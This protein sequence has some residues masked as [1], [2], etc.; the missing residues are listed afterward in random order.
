M[1]ISQAF[2]NRP[3]Y[4]NFGIRGQTRQGFWKFE[5]GRNVASLRKP[6][7]VPLKR[8]RKTYLVEQRWMKEV[9]NRAYLRTELFD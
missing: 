9:R 5:I 1:D 3:E 4:C 7:H 8:G 6:I 2:L